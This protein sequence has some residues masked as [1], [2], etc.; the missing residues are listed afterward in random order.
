MD[1]DPQ[2]SRALAENSPDALLLHD[3]DCRFIWVNERACR[4]LG[5]SRDEL[6]GADLSIAEPDFDRFGFS[7]ALRSLA[8]D[9]RLEVEGR[10]R[11]A[12]G[13]ALAVEVT[14]APILMPGQPR[15]YLAIVRD[16]TRRTAI[17]EARRGALERAERLRRASERELAA[18]RT[19]AAQATGTA[20][21]HAQV[22]ASGAYG[23][24]NAEQQ[25]QLASL[26]AAIDTVDALVRKE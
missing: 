25:T 7:E 8:P 24:L 17:D 1:L 11:A 15:L 3:V 14:V 5:R 16:I 20:R 10:P 26:M 13:T 23:P 4:L 6:L 19:A 9:E 12:D 18:L 22:L 2:L 21:G